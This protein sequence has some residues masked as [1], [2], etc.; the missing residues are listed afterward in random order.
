MKSGFDLKRELAERSDEDWEYLGSLSYPCIAEIGEDERDQYFPLGELQF[1]AEDF[2]DCASRSPLNILETKFNY[3]LENNKLSKENHDW[4][5]DNGYVD[6]YGVTFSDRFVAIN[7]GTTRN[8]NSLKSPLEAIRK[9]GLIPKK[10]LPKKEN[11]KWSDYHDPKS[12]TKKMRDLGEEFTKR[13]T[14]NYEKVYESEFGSLLKKDM[15]DVAGYAWPKPINGVYPKV[16]YQ[17]NHAFMCFKNAFFIFDNYL[18]VDQ[19]Y[20]KHLARDYDFMDYGYRVYI[21]AEKKPC[22]G[23]FSFMR[24]LLS[25]F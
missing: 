8:G 17:P 25:L 7:S 6:Q 23:T 14:I 10:M 5:I 22:S 21:T 3:L 18:D 9:Q 13:F 1:G 2:M 4:L 19:D 12:I 20:V 11:M 15:L 16:Q 24:S